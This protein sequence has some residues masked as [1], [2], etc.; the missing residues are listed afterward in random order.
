MVVVVND[1]VDD[2]TFFYYYHNQRK[3][4]DD[5]ETYST[6]PAFYFHILNAHCMGGADRLHCVGL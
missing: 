1:D 2:V 4:R 5:T 3:E 6:N